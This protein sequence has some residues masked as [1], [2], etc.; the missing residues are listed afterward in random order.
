VHTEEEIQRAAKLAEEIGPS[1]VSTD[2][3]TDLR[4]LA[5]AVNAARARETR[6]RELVAQARVNGRSW[7]EIGIAL[8]VSR[9]AARE[10]FADKIPAQARDVH[11][12]SHE[13]APVGTPRVRS[14]TRVVVDGRYTYETDLELEVG[15]QVLLPASGLGGQWV[16]RVTALS[17][18]Y[19]GPCK[20]LVGLVRRHVDVERQDAAL[21]AVP[22]TGFRAGTTLEVTASCGHPVLLHIEGVNRAGCPTHVK[23]TC[24]ACGG[25]PRSA[26]LGFADAWRRLAAG[27]D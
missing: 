27:L 23:Y 10:R 8:G 3:T 12:G 18:E 17:S 4:T 26:G 19:S 22:I 6:V 14:V 25:I 1:S 21:A 9:H 7:G 15:D 11:A 13:P 20:R 2:D 24:E 5:E 16:A